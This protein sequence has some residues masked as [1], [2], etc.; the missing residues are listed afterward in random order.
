[1][2]V[3]LARTVP[4]V[5]V[6]YTYLFD[7]GTHTVIYLLTIRTGDHTVISSL[8]DGAS[9]HCICLLVDVQVYHV[10]YIVLVFDYNTIYII[11]YT[12]YYST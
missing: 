4:T 10:R 9:S 2:Y 12:D 6:S 11:Q 3:G 1:M 8:V 7:V 5:P